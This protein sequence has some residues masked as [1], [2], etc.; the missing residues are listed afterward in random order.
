M[1][2][3]QEEVEWSWGLPT[4]K[5]PRGDVAVAVACAGFDCSDN[6]IV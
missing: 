2:W 4:W 6:V 1:E 3:A 5:M